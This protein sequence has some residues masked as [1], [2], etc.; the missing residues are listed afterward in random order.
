MKKLDRSGFTLVELL[1][2]VAIL[3][4]IMLIAIPNISSSIE[5]SNERKDAAMEKMV[6]NAGELYV[7]RHRSSILKNIPCYISTSEDLV[8]EGYLDRDEVSDYL[9]SC[10]LYDGVSFDYEKSGNC[11]SNKCISG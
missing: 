6:K 3:V 5:R 10:L 1:A 7:S 2:V 9:N 11:G 4:I 8:S